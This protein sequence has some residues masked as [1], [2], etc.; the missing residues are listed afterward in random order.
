M[1]RKCAVF[2]VVL[3]TYLLSGTCF[4]GQSTITI[5]EGIACMGDDKSRKETQ[6]AA[7]AEAKRDAVERTMTYVT[8][9]KIVNKGMLKKDLME[10]YSRASIKILEVLEKAW[11][12]DPSAGDCFR[13][14]IRAEIVPDVEAIKSAQN[15]DSLYEDP[16]G[17]LAIRVWT[18]KKEYS[19]GEKIKIY[20]KGNKPFFARVVYQDAS[21]NLLQLLPNIHR[22]QNY[23]NGGTVYE[24]P[25]GR[26]SFELDVTPPFGRENIIVY[27]STKALGHVDMRDVG[28]VYAI[29]SSLDDVRGKT[30]GV[31]I[32]TANGGQDGPAE[33]YEA[34]TDVTISR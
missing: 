3:I 6:S 24:I 31:A 10:A 28:G 23:F 14:K 25:S 29:N 26:D 33:F 18:N 9:D 1:K 20:L 11:E 22:T 34:Q 27:A 2:T 13:M 30:R 8:S 15:L 32:R 19:K 16:S 5:A 17:P 4:A 7:M 12:K 21:G